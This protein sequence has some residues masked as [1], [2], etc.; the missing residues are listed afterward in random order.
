MIPWTT[1]LEQ[2]RPSVYMGAILGISSWAWQT[3][4]FMMDVGARIYKKDQCRPFPGDSTLW[5]KYLIAD[6]IMVL[7]AFVTSVVCTYA[8]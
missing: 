2:S 8:L 1:A 7:P 3:F 5:K 4:A 6:G